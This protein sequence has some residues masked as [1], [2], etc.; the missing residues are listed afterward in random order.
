MPTSIFPAGGG[1][2]DPF[3]RRPQQH[4]DGRQVVRVRITPDRDRPSPVEGDHDR[5]P[6]PAEPRA[7][8][9]GD[10]R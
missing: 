10:L 8:P 5:C 6:R 1:V 4:A 9:L 2:V 3:P 7:W